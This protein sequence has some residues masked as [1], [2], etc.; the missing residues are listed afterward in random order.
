MDMKLPKVTH[1]DYCLY[2]LSGRMS[3][4]K[5]SRAFEAA[6]LDVIK[7]VSPEILSGILAA[8]LP[9]CLSNFKAIGKDYT[10]ISRLR[11]F[12]RSCG[13]TH[14]RLVH[15][16]MDERSFDSHLS[17]CC[18]A[19]TNFACIASLIADKTLSWDDLWCVFSSGLIGKPC[20]I[21]EV[22]ACKKDDVFHD[23]YKSRSQPHQ[24]RV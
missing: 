7:I 2:S 19:V 3:Y 6:R 21:P 8:L 23:W 15:E 22:V 16:R 20:I 24:L 4:H 1:R 5:I 17:K 11:D 10:R 13:K 18:H 9:R 14:T 12:T